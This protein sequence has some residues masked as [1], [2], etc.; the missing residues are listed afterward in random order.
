MKKFSALVALLFCA[1]L[2]HAGDCKVSPPVTVG[3]GVTCVSAAY[4]FGVS[5]G[6]ASIAFTPTAT[7]QLVFFGWQ[8]EFATGSVHP[9]GAGNDWAASTAYAKTNSC[10]NSG[11]SSCIQP[12]LKNPCSYAFE[13]LTTGTSGATEPTWST[14]PCQNSPALVV[15]G[16]LTWEAITMTIQNQAG[17]VLSCFTWSQSIP[18]ELQNTT[19]TTSSFINFAAYC[20]NAPSGITSIQLVPSIATATQ[21]SLM[22]QEYTGLC[23]TAPCI[24]VD[25]YNSNPTSTATTLT[26]NTSF[27]NNYTNEMVVAF[28]ST[29]NDEALTPVSPCAFIDPGSTESPA[30]STV[31]IGQIVT[32]AGVTSGCGVTWTGG[33][34][35]GGL[36]MAIKTA[37]ST[38]GGG[39]TV[40][41]NTTS[42]VNTT[43]L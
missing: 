38:G 41:V 34:T 24:D 2:A 18:Q 23:T 17:T 43:L 35:A 16:S 42:L 10:F 22:V 14:L 3:G 30:N 20:P 25:G 6:A 13:V 33:D 1:V 9:C 31:V 8:C 11:T 21:T 7:H 12:L 29:N 39:T 36:V 4:I 32:A 37:L 28:I 26:V 40:L 5:S 27:A 15:D 19:G